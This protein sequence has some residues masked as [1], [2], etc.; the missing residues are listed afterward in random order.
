MSIRDLSIAFGLQVDESQLIAADKHL[1]KMVADAKAAGGKLGGSGGGDGGDDGKDDAAGLSTMF[2]QAKASLLGF[3]AVSGAK[4]AF[5]WLTDQAAIGAHLDD[6]AT[7]F[8]VSTDEL[9]QFQLAAELAGVDSEGAAQALGF[10]QKNIGLAANGSAEA[11]KSFKELG[12]S[13]RE[14]DGSIRP[15]LDVTEDIADAMEA[16]G[17]EAE[18]AGKLV[19]VFGKQGAALIP[20]LKDGSKGLRTAYDDFARLGGGMDKDF[21]KKAAEADDEMARM[22]FAAKGLGSQIA[23]ALIP[24]LSKFAH[25]TAEVAGG[26]KRVAQNSQIV[27]ASLI[28]MSGGGLLLAIPKLIEMSKA[29]G[30]VKKS[31]TGIEA[32]GGLFGG[33]LG[34]AAAGIALA[35]IVALFEDLYQLMTGGKSLIGETL[36]ELEGA[37]TAADLAQQLRDAWAALGDTW[38]ELSPTVSELGQLLLDIGKDAIP[39]MI[40]GFVGTIKVV[41]ALALAVAGLIKL[42]REYI[43]TA[44]DIS[45]IFAKGGFNAD[46]LNKA[47]ARLTQGVDTAG[48]AVDQTGDAI[49]G[50][51]LTTVNADGTTDS[52]NVGGLFGM[53]QRK[54]D[55]VLGNTGQ[56]SYAS[57]RDGGGTTN[58]PNIT[59]MNTI[60][61]T[62]NG[63]DAKDIADDV[64]TKLPDVL[65]DKQLRNAHR[66][67]TKGTGR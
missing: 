55:V 31:A 61:I 16:T 23:V 5:S 12:V 19:K 34:L 67:V 51:S 14:A 21:I 41:A 43:S 9:Q 10:L 53:S 38:E 29:F 17:S 33:G 56:S 66:S 3:L 39:Y 1:A 18:M 24:Y 25:V 26:I 45:D 6:L 35:V 47:K 4:A 2:D 60:T 11:E 28:A 7:K 44:L 37:G 50:K 59:Q 20:L 40:Q 54:A 32:L 58:N 63:T 65:N 49:F 15:L 57:Q 46:S 64:A 27:K 13:Y 30:L 62:A 48:K 42:V 8:G 36:D 22:R 52:T